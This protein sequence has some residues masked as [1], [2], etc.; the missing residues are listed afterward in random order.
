ML[1]LAEEDGHTRRSPD[2]D[3]HTEGLEE[4]Q[5]REGQSKPCDSK[6][7]DALTDEDAVDDAVERVDHRP[8]NSW[9]TIV[10]EEAW[11]ALVS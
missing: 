8:H 6:F 10:N 11:Y 5:D 4:D 7:T 2:A 3:K 9:D 1:V